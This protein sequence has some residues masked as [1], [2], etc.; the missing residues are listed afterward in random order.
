MLSTAEIYTK[1]ITY[2]FTPTKC[3]FLYFIYFNFLDNMRGSKLVY[4]TA[5]P[6]AYL[7]PFIDTEQSIYEVSAYSC[8]I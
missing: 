4:I 2:I 1:R 6:F 5:Q 7:I 3:I 8:Y